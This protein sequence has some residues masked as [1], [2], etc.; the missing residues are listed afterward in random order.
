MEYVEHGFEPV[1]DK[2]SKILILGTLPS[3][4]SRENQFYYGHPHNRFWKVLKALTG[5]PKDLLTI[6]DKK[7]MLLQSG[8]AVWDVIKSCHITGSSDSSIKNVT[9]NDLTLI[10]KAAPIKMIYA[11]GNKAYELYNRYCKD[12]I[13]L[14]VEKLPSTSP[15][16][17]ACS[18]D[19][20]IQIWE[21]QIKKSIT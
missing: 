6:E 2:H 10:L 17:A 3:V 8:I 5:W 13:P 14:P 15:A 18:L 16:N 11:N 12:T 1:F 9:P 19:K 21:N 20:L 4:K 7:E